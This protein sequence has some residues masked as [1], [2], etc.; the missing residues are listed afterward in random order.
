M[1]LL[2]WIPSRKAILSRGLEKSWDAWVW[3]SAI[4]NKCR[5]LQSS[6]TANLEASIHV[7]IWCG[8]PG[9]GEGRGGI[10]V[11]LFTS[12]QSSRCSSSCFPLHVLIRTGTWFIILHFRQSNGD[13]TFYFPGHACIQT[14]VQTII[15]WS[16]DNNKLNVSYAYEIIMLLMLSNSEEK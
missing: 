14:I 8:Y 9:G 11:V 16:S 5:L 3:P 10:P 6:G 7:L 1:Y 15:Q 2:Y 12:Q 13:L 4:V